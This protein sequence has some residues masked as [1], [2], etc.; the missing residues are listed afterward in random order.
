MNLMQYDYYHLGVSTGKDST[1]ALLWLIYESGIP[2]DR[3]IVTMCDTGNE[4]KL[5]YAMRDYLSSEV[6][7]ITTLYPPLDFYQLALKKHRFPSAKARF[8]TQHLKV[9]PSREYVLDLMRDGSRVLL[10]SGVRWEEAAPG[11]KRGTVKRFEFDPGWGTDVYRPIVDW[12]ISAVWEIA[13]KYLSY[14]RVIELVNSDESMNDENKDEIIKRI[15]SHKIPRNPLY[16]IGASRVGCFPCINSRK[17]EIRAMAKYRPE[18]VKFIAKW[19]RTV[20]ETRAVSRYSSMFARNSVPKNHRSKTIETKDGR[21]MQVATIYDVVN[22]SMTAMYRPNQFS[23][24]PDIME[25]ES[26]CDIGGFCE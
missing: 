13:K 12:T 19:E 8:C 5:T 6:F 23:F 18:R 17:R 3:I 11:N 22:W 25:L 1:A 21:T 20:G 14:S 2:H 24:D 26:T 10:M 15:E 4:D 9:I 16:D 7:P